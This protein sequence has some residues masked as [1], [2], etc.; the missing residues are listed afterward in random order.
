MVTIPANLKP[1]PYV[2]GFRWDC[3]EYVFNVASGG[4]FLASRVPRAARAALPACLP[5]AGRF[6]A[7]RNTANIGVCCSTEG[8]GRGAR[9]SG[10]WWLP[11]VAGLG[12]R[13]REMCACCGARGAACRC[14]VACCFLP[15]VSPGLCCGLAPP[16]R[17]SNQIWSSCSD[18]NVV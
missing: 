18:I 11:V 7:P 6:G 12:G 17:R 16:P 9:R 10:C 2:V 4:F 5:W 15:S 14:V 13:R 8:R 3:E 1:G